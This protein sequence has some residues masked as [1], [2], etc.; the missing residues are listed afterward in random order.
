MQFAENEC[1]N[2]VQVILVKILNFL[3]R[4]GYQKK[5]KLMKL[6]LIW[7]GLKYM[8]HFPGHI[9]IYLC[10]ITNNCIVMV[11]KICP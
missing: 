11:S 7:S 3:L 5:Q 6:A 4:K 9:H 8:T 10:F 2:R 1:K